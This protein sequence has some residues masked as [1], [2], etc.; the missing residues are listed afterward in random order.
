MY[1]VQCTVVWCGVVWCGVVW[2]GCRVV[3]VPR[4]RWQGLCCAIVTWRVSVGLPAA[5]RAIRFF[6]W[7]CACLGERWDALRKGKR[8]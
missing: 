6:S 2:C 8:D 4:V 1:S 5:W 7:L 3:R